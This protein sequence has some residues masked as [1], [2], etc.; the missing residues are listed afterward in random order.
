MKWFDTKKGYGFI[1]TPE[2]DCFVHYKNISDKH[3]GFAN[4]NKGEKV[5]L[6]TMTNDRGMY[7]VE[8]RRYG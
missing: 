7:A 6:E 2:G 3:E 4:L 1:S 5:T 8:V